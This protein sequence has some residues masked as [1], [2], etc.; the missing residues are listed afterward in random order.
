MTTRAKFKV[1]EIT[2]RDFGKS[3]IL[4]PVY[5]S[6][7]NSEN[8]KFYKQTPGGKIEIMTIN[9]EVSKQFSI[10]KQFYIDFTPA[11]Q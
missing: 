8:G 1:T 11:E 7:P 9:E 6:D 10:G 2:E 5:S 3:L 4:Q